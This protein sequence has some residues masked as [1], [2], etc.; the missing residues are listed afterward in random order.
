[1]QPLMLSLPGMLEA[2]GEF[3]HA[4]LMQNENAPR[5][6]KRDDALC[7][8]K[9]H[10]EPVPPKLLRISQN[11]ALSKVFPHQLKSFSAFVFF[12]GFTSSNWKSYTI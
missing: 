9:K 6:E 7:I 1:M 2:M 12:K 10:S 11:S 4:R 3:Y 5:I 8:M